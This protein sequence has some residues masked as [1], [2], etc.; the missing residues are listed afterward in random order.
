MEWTKDVSSAFIYAKFV[1]RLDTLDLTLI[2]KAL[3]EDPIIEPQ[4]W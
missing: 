2:L 4:D 1:L 3:Y